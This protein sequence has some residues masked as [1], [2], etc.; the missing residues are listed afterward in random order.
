MDSM[1]V[2]DLHE[3]RSDLLYRVELL[4]AVGPYQPLFRFV[5]DD[6]SALSVEAVAARPLDP[7]ARLVELALWASR[8][9]RRIE[10]V[11]PHLRPFFAFT[12]DESMCRRK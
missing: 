11:A 9:L 10:Q 1:I 12:L 2:H 5:L 8:S 7:M 3:T 6:L 4:A